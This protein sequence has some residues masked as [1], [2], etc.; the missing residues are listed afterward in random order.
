MRESFCKHFLCTA[1]LQ[2]IRFAYMLRLNISLRCLFRYLHFH[3]NHCTDFT[4]KAFHG[5]GPGYLLNFPSSTR[6]GKVSEG[7][8]VS[9]IK[10]CHLMGPRRHAFSIIVPTLWNNIYLRYSWPN[11]LAFHQV[12]FFGIEPEIESIW[13]VYMCGYMSCPEFNVFLLILCESEVFNLMSRITWQVG[14]HSN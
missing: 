13:E 7:L 2:P 9:S 6:Y 5:T 3:I 1:V 10:Q 8:Q 4:F 14:N 11:L 12:F